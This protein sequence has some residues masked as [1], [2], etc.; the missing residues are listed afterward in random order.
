MSHFEAIIPSSPTSSMPIPRRSAVLSSIEP[1]A[2][3]DAADRNRSSPLSSLVRLMELAILNNLDIKSS[4]GKRE[5][6][7]TPVRRA[8]ISRTIL[9][10]VMPQADRA[11]FRSENR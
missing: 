2:P 3:C 6:S 7:S 11:D 8:S 10:G 9:P 4:A 1:I 5:R